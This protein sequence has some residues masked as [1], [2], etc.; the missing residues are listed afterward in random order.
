MNY[1][2]AFGQ[3]CG[4]GESV[5]HVSYENEYPFLTCPPLNH[6]IFKLLKTCCLQRK[7]TE[8]ADLIGQNV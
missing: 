2:S 6:H 3:L 8:I 7:K 5:M 4:F 1:L